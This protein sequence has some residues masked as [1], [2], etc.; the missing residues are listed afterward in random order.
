MGLHLRHGSEGLDTMMR[1]ADRALYDAKAAGKNR[2]VLAP[3]RL[4]SV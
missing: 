4:R 2:A 3:V 1:S